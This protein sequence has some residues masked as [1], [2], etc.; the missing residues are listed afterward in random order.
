MDDEYIAELID[1]ER[2][3][4][5]EDTGNLRTGIDPYKLELRH[6]G[7]LRRKDF[8]T[9]FKNFT[10]DPSQ[11]SYNVLA[12]LA[13]TE[14]RRNLIRQNADPKLEKLKL[15]NQSVALT[16]LMNTHL[17]IGLKPEVLK[18]FTDLDK[19]GVDAAFGLFEREINRRQKNKDERVKL[20][21]DLLELEVTDT[22][23]DDEIKQISSMKLMGWKMLEKENLVPSPTKKTGG[24]NKAF[25]YSFDVNQIKNN[26]LVELDGQ[27]LSGKKLKELLAGNNISDEELSKLKISR[28]GKIKKSSSPSLFSPRYYGS[29]VPQDEYKQEQVKI[30]NKKEIDKEAK[31]LGWNDKIDPTSIKFQLIKEQLE[32]KFPNYNF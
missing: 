26:D 24:G 27:K 25:D 30:A 10:K 32:K 9:A 21:K 14:Q 6:E 12:E 11:E 13:D 3:N 8:N 28:A 20:A 31:R 15:K 23:S 18:Q 2:W 19:I 17:K 5:N 7:I 22:M 29:M 1:A 16:Q 4:I